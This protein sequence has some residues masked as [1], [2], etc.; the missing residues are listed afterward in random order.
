VSDPR[1][2]D[3]ASAVRDAADKAKAAADKVKEKESNKAKGR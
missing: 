2:R 1:A 3:T